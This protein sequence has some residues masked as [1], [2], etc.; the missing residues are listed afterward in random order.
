MRHLAIE[1]SYYVVTRE[2]PW[3]TRF[4]YSAKPGLALSNFRWYWDGNEFRSFSDFKQERRTYQT[5]D[6]RQESLLG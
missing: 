2:Y 5:A 4:L 6:I 1:L 3:P